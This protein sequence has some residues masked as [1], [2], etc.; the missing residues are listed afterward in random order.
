MCFLPRHIFFVGFKNERRRKRKKKVA[1]KKVIKKRL[2]KKA[3]PRWLM[4]SKN[5]VRKTAVLEREEKKNERKSSKKNGFKK[6][7]RKRIR[8]IS[9]LAMAFSETY[10][11]YQIKFVPLQHKTQ[12]SVCES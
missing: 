1:K 10:C 3:I 4:C 11:T 7:L 2:R 5:D 12:L 6:R 8:Y 9:I